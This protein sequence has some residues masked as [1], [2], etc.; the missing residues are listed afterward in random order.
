M[1][2]RWT[3]QHFDQAREATLNWFRH[4]RSATTCTYLHKVLLGEGSVPEGWTYQNQLKVMI[5]LWPNIL[6]KGPWLPKSSRG[7]PWAF[8]PVEAWLHED[9]QGRNTLEG[10]DLDHIRQAFRTNTEPPGTLPGMKPIRIP[11][12]S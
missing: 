7:N 12:A 10:G 3:E 8:R 4:W 5:G 11:R 2:I 9:A 6:E 1:R